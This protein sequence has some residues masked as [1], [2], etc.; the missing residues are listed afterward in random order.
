M[1]YRCLPCDYSFASETGLKDHMQTVHHVMVLGTCPICT[2]PLL[3]TERHVGPHYSQRPGYQ[4]V[5]EACY[6]VKTITVPAPEP[7]PVTKV[8]KRSAAA[9]AVFG[10]R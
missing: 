6:P 3:S 2:K 5:H 8:R 9:R 4:Y 1:T 7:D 10:G